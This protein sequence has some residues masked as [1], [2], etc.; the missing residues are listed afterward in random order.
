M[1]DRLV[2]LARARKAAPKVRE[3]TA[4]AC[5]RRVQ[6]FETLIPWPALAA[7]WRSDAVAI[8]KMNGE[9]HA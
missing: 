5:D 8:R 9:S 1:D 2:M 3:V 7:S 4:R 6:M